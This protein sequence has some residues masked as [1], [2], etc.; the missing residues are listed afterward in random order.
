MKTTDSGPV[1]PRVWIDRSPDHRPNFGA[2]MLYEER[3]GMFPNAVEF[4]HVSDL[5]A[6]QKRIAELEICAQELIAVLNTQTIVSS[7]VLVKKSALES[8]LTE[9]PEDA[10]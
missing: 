10:K 2:L 9:K 4:C 1:P 7:S 8:L 6:A 3:P 5:E